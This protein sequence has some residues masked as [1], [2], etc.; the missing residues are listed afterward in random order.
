MRSK[1]KLFLF[2]SFILLL[3]AAIAGCAGSDTKEELDA[4]YDEGY[5]KGYAAGRNDGYNIGLA[6]GESANKEAVDASYDRGYKIG[7]E[8]GSGITIEEDYQQYFVQGNGYLAQEKWEE[9]IA[10]YTMAIEINPSYVDAYIKRATAYNE[11]SDYYELAILD[12]EKAIELDPL[13]KLDSLLARAYLNRGEYNA[14]FIKEEF[15]GDD[16]EGNKSTFDNAVAD[17][18]KAI[19]LNPRLAEAYYGRGDCYTTYFGDSND[20]GMSGSYDNTVADFS[21]AISLDPTNAT[22]YT[23]RAWAYHLGDDY[24]RELVDETKAIE[25]DPS[26][27]SYYSSRGYTYLSKKNYTKAVEDFTKAIELG[28]E[29]YWAY[30]SRGDAHVGQ[31]SYD[32]AIADYTKAIEL[33]SKSYYLQWAYTDRGHAYKDKGEYDK[34]IADYTEAIELDTSPSSTYY[35]YRALAYLEQQNYNSAIADSSKAIELYPEGDDAYWIR[36]QAYA[37]LGQKDE[38]LADFMECLALSEEW[39]KYSSS[40]RE[41]NELVRQEIEKLQSD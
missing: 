36:G 1:W 22:Y 12:C 27:A 14:Q 33:T 9:A 32:L 26:N 41:R 24:A 16:Y 13:V 10:K 34:A 29:D 3:V 17:F 39:E 21:M 8:A 7:Y 28:K 37:A 38:A 6:E 23:G 2:M 35:N 19:E 15:Y 5:S 25:L 20:F 4:A 31:G 30:S 40:T 18:T 11:M